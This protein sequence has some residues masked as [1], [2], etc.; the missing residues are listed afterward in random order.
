[1][2]DTKVDLIP[3]IPESVHGIM[4]VIPMAEVLDDEDFNCRGGRIDAFDVAELAKDIKQRGLIEPVVVTEMTAENQKIRGKKYLLVVGYR[5]FT[6]CK[7][8]QMTEINSVI[9]HFNSEADARCFNIS[10]NTSTYRQTC[11]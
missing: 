5:R 1:M 11:P 7:L 6:A 8:I 2:P 4:K 3:T 9:R 10:D